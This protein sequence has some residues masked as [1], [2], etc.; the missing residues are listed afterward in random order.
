M[1]RQW[2]TVMSNVPGM[3][4]SALLLVYIPLR[5]SEKVEHS[6]A[7]LNLQHQELAAIATTH[8]VYACAAQCLMSS[9]CQ[10]GAE[11]CLACSACAAV[12]ELYICFH[13]LMWQYVGKIQ[14]NISNLHGLPNSMCKVWP[15]V[16]HY[17][18][19]LA[20]LICS[21]WQGSKVCQILLQSITQVY[22]YQGFDSSTI[23]HNISD[24]WRGRLWK[25]SSSAHV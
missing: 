5:R 7:V 22:L 2:C 21:S 1:M 23:Y 20:S 13:C 12:I 6:L 10:G 16:M 4:W 9:A 18:A 3:A 8:V 24:F 19:D 25:G 14:C 11:W 17:K 15:Q